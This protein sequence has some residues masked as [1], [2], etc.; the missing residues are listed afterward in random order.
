[1]IV[2]E[3]DAKRD[4]KSMIQAKFQ[5]GASKDEREIR[6]VVFMQEQGFVDEFD[7][8]DDS[9]WHLVIYHDGKAIGCGRILKVDPETYRIGRVAVL[10]EYRGHQVGTYIVKFLQTKIKELGGRKAILL[11]QAD[12][13][14]FYEKL[15]FKSPTG[16]IIMEEDYPHIYMEKIL[17]KTDPK[18]R[19]RVYKP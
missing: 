18:R 3:T 10:K 11:S 6:T 4:N 9:C 7:A 15:G 12:K 5:I 14:A 2:P 16:E 13:S 17:V 8:E 19:K 1:M